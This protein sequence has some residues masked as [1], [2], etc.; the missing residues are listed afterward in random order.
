MMRTIEEYPLMASVG[1]CN[2]GL[3]CGV[4]KHPSDIQKARKGQEKP[5]NKKDPLRER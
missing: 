5:N 2:G 4:G 3:M 1:R